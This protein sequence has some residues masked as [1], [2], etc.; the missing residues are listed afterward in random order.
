MPAPVWRTSITGRSSAA[1]FG[2]L[3]VADYSAAPFSLGIGVTV[4]STAPTFSVE[5]TYDYTGS[6][7]FISSNATWFVVTGFSSV[8]GLNTA[9]FMELPTT[10]LRLNISSGSTATSTASV[11]M[12]I[13]R[14][15]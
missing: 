3:Y 12:T 5:H 6:S 8:L 7:T 4:T 1:G 15:G 13:V 14:A 9:G 10:A 11:S 2:N